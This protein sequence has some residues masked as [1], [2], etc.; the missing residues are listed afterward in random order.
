MHGSPV[1][2]HLCGRTGRTLLLLDEAARRT[3][4]LGRLRVSIS[5]ARILRCSRSAA[6]GRCDPCLFAEGALNTRYQPLVVW[7]VIAVSSSRTRFKPVSA[8]R[9]QVRKP[10]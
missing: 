4:T 3:E 10:V 2:P 9:S 6:A 7:P 5:I 1:L 8:S